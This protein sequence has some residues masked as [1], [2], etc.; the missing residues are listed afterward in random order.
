MCAVCFVCCVCC[1]C[2]GRTW[3]VILTHLSSFLH[4]FQGHY[5][6]PL[7]SQHAALFFQ[8]K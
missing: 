8:I 6:V 1:V 5:A 4:M 3:Q 2:L 7:L